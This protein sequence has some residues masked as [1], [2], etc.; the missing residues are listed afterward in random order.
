MLIPAFDS[1]FPSGSSVPLWVPL[2]VPIQLHPL[3]HQHQPPAKKTKPVHTT[4]LWKR[5][6]LIKCG[7]HVGSGGS[8]CITF[9][10]QH[11][12]AKPKPAFRIHPVLQ[13]QGFLQGLG[14]TQSRSR[15]ALQQI[16]FPS[17]LF[18]SFPAPSL[19]KT[20]ILNKT[21]ISGRAVRPFLSGALTLPTLSLHLLTWEIDQGLF[22]DKGS[23]PE[24]SS[25]D[26]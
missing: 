5:Q 1:Y 18:C 19:E 2:D 13:H 22:P 25:D 11:Q 15:I 17:L 8:H 26:K 23:F 14:P 24:I 7:S 21:N 16:P 20:T 10:K 12:I 6:T 4:Y 9:C 3:H